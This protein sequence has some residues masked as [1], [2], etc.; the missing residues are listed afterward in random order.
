MF[1]D[2]SVFG[3]G[4]SCSVWVL[5]FLSSPRFSA[6]TVLAYQAALK[7]FLG[8]CGRSGVVCPDERAI[9]R[10]RA[11]LLERYKLSTAQSYFAVVKVFFSWLGRHGLYEDVA[12]GVKG[13]SVNRSVPLRDYLSGNDMM[14]VLSLL[15]RRADLSGS[16]HAVRDYVMV[17]LM[18]CCGLRVTEVTRLDVGDVISTSSGHQ[19]LVHGKGRDGKSDAVNVPDGVVDAIHRW[20][21]VRSAE[22]KHFTKATPLFVSFGG[23]NDGG[24]LCSRT[25][26]QIVKRALVNA[27]FDSPRLTAHSLRHTAVT[28]ALMAGAS[29]QEA[30]Q[31]ARHSRIETTQIYAHNLE[32]QSNRCSRLVER[33]VIGG[34][35]RGRKN[36]HIYPKRRERRGI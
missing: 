28:L 16:V 21:C 1:S 13:V 20:L 18:V 12:C 25:V 33:M 10:Y 8:W 11:W 7:A 32:A 19:I 24:R 3:A 22:V 30:Q 14:R 23:R 29:L 36:P 2:C 15:R 6:S 34:M 9:V 17:L 31:Y 27:G 4:D 35:T 5:R 26:S